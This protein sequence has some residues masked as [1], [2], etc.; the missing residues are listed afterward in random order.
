VPTND[1]KSA[2]ILGALSYLPDGNL[3]FGGEPEILFNIYRRYLQDKIRENKNFRIISTGHLITNAGKKP[4]YYNH[5]E[6]DYN[7]DDFIEEKRI[8]WGKNGHTDK[9]APS[10]K[11]D[12][13]IILNDIFASDNPCPKETRKK[14]EIDCTSL[15]EKYSDFIKKHLENI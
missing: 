6:G 2:Q 15:W 5:Q 9:I 4:V 13:L 7:I 8:N 1:K 11:T 10:V 12:L 3:S 14:S